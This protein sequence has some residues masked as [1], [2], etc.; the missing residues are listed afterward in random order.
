MGVRRRQILWG[1]AAMAL[2]GAVYVLTLT[3]PQEAVPA[4]AERL[5]QAVEIQPLCGTA[6][7]MDVLETAEEARIGAGRM[8]GRGSAGY[9]HEDGG[10]R[11]LGTMMDTREEAEK[12][13]EKLNVAGIAAECYSVSGE[14]LT[15]KVTAAQSQIDALTDAIHAVDMAAVQ[16]G[17]IAGQLDSAEIDGDRARGLVAMLVSDLETAQAD[18]RDTGAQG[19]L[20]E[21]LDGLMSEAIDMLEP[22]TEDGGERNLMLA[23]EIRCAGMAVWFAREE[24]IA[25]LKGE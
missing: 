2:S 17:R 21:R 19:A 20:S 15:L 10:Y 13:R 23:G 18:F 22:L 9:V 5:T 7:E 6:I 8:V 25:A 14:G 16:P 4:A 11:V 12:M 24:M 1:L 3:Q